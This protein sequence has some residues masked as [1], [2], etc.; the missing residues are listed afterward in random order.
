MRFCQITWGWGMIT[1]S[2]L[3]LIPDVLRQIKPYEDAPLRSCHCSTFHSYTAIWI[4]NIN[5]LRSD[6]P[7]F[8]RLKVVH[9]CGTDRERRRAPDPAP[10]P[11]LLVPVPDGTE[12]TFTLRGSLPP[13]TAAA[14]SAQ[15]TDKPAL[16]DEAARRGMLGGMLW[17]FASWM[18]GG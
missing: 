7:V 5:P 14:A 6:R 11:P 2:L 18:D 15:S 17:A 3:R 8:V 9:R 13:E 16:R 10:P 1:Q 12:S 4:E